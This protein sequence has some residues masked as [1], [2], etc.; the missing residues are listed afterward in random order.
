VLVV[1]SDTAA[2]AMNRLLFDPQEGVT[3]GGLGVVLPAL[4]ASVPFS[5][6]A[7]A[8]APVIRNER[9]RHFVEVVQVTLTVEPSD[10][11]AIFHRARI[12]VLPVDG[13]RVQ[14]VAATALDA[15]GLNAKMMR[16]RSPATI[17]DGNCTVADVPLVVTSVPLLLDATV[18]KP[19]A[20][21]ANNIRK[22]VDAITTSPSQKSPTWC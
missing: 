2:T 12:K 13:I 10:P 20:S 9:I 15:D 5:G 19:P 18:G 6:A 7:L 3:D 17:P 14:P 22:L 11:V 1:P 21:A 4:V 16:R 8:C